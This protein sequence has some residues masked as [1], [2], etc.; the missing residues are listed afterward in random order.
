MLSIIGESH[1]IF[2]W[3]Y[4][5]K[6]KWFNEKFILKCMKKAAQVDELEIVK[7]IFKK[8]ERNTTINFAK[9]MECAIKKKSLKVVKWF[10][11]NTEYFKKFD[12]DWLKNTTLDEVD[13]FCQLGKEFDL[14]YWCIES[15]Y[16]DRIDL[17]KYFLNKIHG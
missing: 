16:A 8:N 3:L 10:Q 2:E 15:L 13:C 1:D 4:V 7:F 5:Q 11:E 9:A 6:E 14:K 12:N 17:A